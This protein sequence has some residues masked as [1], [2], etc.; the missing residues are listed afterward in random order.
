M[1]QAKTM[2][3]EQF[4]LVF[5]IF[6]AIKKGIIINHENR[7]R[8]MEIELCVT[9]KQLKLNVVSDKKARKMATEK[10]I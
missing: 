7:T 5:T 6:V 8:A 1:Y 4:V 2:A 10:C 3:I 9:H